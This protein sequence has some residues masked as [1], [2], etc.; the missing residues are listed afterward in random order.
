MDDFWNKRYSDSEHAYGEEPNEYFRQKLEL[1]KPGKL[2]LPAEGEGRN[3]VYAASKGWEVTAV[4]SSIEG[5]SKALNLAT[6]KSVE[7]K[8]IV[9]PLEEFS[10]PENA[11]DAV[12][13][14]YGH[15]KSNVRK[16]I[17]SSILKSMKAEG[18]LIMEV[19]SKEQLQNSSGGPKDID[20]LNS[21]D[22]IRSDFEQLEIIELKE[23]TI[24]LNEGQYHN[25]E[26]KVIRLFGKK[27][28]I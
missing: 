20:M 25:G 8:Y 21:L 22:E 28:A 5:Q 7:I 1:L 26:A 13:L 19:F 24:G 17:H 18:H 2:S 15:F 14:I 12:A 9:S 27:S 16:H 3:A 23:T 11:F 4:D 6:R 10:F